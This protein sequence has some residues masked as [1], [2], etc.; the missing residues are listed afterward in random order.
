MALAARCIAEYAS[1]T[2][3]AYPSLEFSPTLHFDAVSTVPSASS[4]PSSLVD[5]LQNTFATKPGEKF[6]LA[7]THSGEVS[8]RR[9]V[10]RTACQNLLRLYLGKYNDLPGP[11][12]ET[13]FFVVA[14]RKACLFCKTT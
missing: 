12:V 14:S 4:D 13:P 3:S 6:R 1:T 11:H 2:S 10:V 7:A 9:R 5:K 8:L